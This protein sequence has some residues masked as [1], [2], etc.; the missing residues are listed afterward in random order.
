VPDGKGGSVDWK[1]EG[2]SVSI[3]IRN[4]WTKDTIKPGDKVRLLI[5]P[6]RDKAPGGEF[7]TV[8]DRNGQKVNVSNNASPQS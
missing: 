3:L 4:G 2:G 8:L 7:F 5:S 1:L 6:R